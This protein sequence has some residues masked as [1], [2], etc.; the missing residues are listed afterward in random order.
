[1]VAGKLTYLADVF[2]ADEYIGGFI[3]WLLGAGRLIYL[4]AIFCADEY[5]GRLIDSCW[6]ADLPGCCILCW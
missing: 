4:A 2:C 5:I 6:Q 1:M 3:D